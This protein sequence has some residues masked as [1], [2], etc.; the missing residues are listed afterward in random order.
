MGVRFYSVVDMYVIRIKNGYKG[1]FLVIFD[2]V[3]VG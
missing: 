2:L 3:V 1:L